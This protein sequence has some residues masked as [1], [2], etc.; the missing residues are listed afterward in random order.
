MIIRVSKK[1]ATLIYFLHKIMHKL[2][3]SFC[4]LFSLLNVSAQSLMPV[5]RFHEKDSKYTFYNNNFLSG[6]LQA[7][8][9]ERLTNG[10]LQM[11]F[12][13]DPLLVY[14]GEKDSTQ[15]MAYA[16]GY[17]LQQPNTNEY[18]VN[19]TRYG[20]EADLQ[21]MPGY[22]VQ[23]YTF[24]DTTIDKGFLLDI[25][26]AGS[27]AQNEDM[28][29]VFIDKRTIR[30][31][32][33]SNQM[34]CGVPDLYY[35]AHFSH[36]FSKWNVRREVVRLENGQRELRCKAAFMFDLPKNEAL[37]VTSAVSAV[38][39]DAAYALLQMGGAKKHFSD[40]RKPQP[41]TDDNHLLAQN[42][43]KAQPR[44]ATTKATRATPTK[45]TARQVAQPQPTQ[46][47]QV[48]QPIVRQVAGNSFSPTKWLEIA[49]RDAELQAAFTAA[50]KQLQQH[51]TKA[52]LATDA[53][54]FIDAIAPSYPTTQRFDA[55]QTDSLLR[56]HAQTLF[57]GQTMTDEQATWF[58]FNAMGFVP[59]EAN[60][61][62]LVR[63]LFNIVTLQLPRTRR[64]I[65]HTKNNTP[66]NCHMK[67]ATLM[68]Q[69]LAADYT[70][71][72]E[73]LT[74]G[75]IMEVKMQP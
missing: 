23:H 17:T 16:S 8:N 72:R 46:P 59:T 64:L 73:Q 51:H 5:T 31:Y 9:N 20:V 34:G 75:G 45:S 54:A 61:Y 27:G 37:T 30:A 66:R 74:K 65:I 69:P 29:V 44:T 15:F 57:M 50:L 36:P 10:F 22:C 41:K 48:Q 28:D 2:L 43:L 60:A 18:Q 11:P 68:H 4:C 58:V 63:P 71:S 1:S 32:K 26:N 33:R 52:K 13:G 47:T 53:L 14:V 25:D 70:F 6:F 39:T 55:L 12:V 67:Q 35:V 38:S 62:Q 40:Q 56:H 3:L 21:A 19:Y 49:T 7:D 42:T 24:P